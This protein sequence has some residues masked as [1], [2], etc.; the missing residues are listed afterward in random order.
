MIPVFVI[1]LVGSDDRRQRITSIFDNLGM[2]F[3]FFDAVD[4]RQF[5]VMQQPIYDAKKRLA[6]YGKHMT[7]GEI[8]CLLSHKALYQKIV[9]E[10]IEKALIFEDDVLLRPGFKAVLD[11]ILDQGLDAPYDMI[12]FLSSPKLERLRLS[13]IH[14]IDKEHYLTRHTG[15]PGGAHASLVRHSGAKKMLDHLSKSAFPI[16]TLMGRSWQTGMNWV[17]VRPGIAAQDREIA[18]II[19]DDLRLERRL[20]IKGIGR[21]L[22]PLT[23][24]WFKLCETIGKKYWYYIQSFKDKIRIKEYE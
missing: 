18:S 14:Y 19:G 24:A 1:S 10:G 20:D 2:E 6:F 22:Y 17:T 5:D 7:G 15:M 8:G 13:P 21:F 16:D 23:R 11:Q 12:R 3:E 9:N 4:G